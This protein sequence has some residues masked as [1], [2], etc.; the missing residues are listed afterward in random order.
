MGSKPSVIAEMCQESLLQM[1]WGVEGVYC[2]I[3]KIIG[4]E[5]S[6]EIEKEYGRGARQKNDI[7]PYKIPYEVQRRITR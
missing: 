1:G 6:K 5:K 4:K 2:C 3:S 7:F